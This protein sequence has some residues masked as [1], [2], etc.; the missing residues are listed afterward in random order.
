MTGKALNDAGDE[1]GVPLYDMTHLTGDLA[2][3]LDAMDIEKAIFTGHDWGGFV[4]WQMPFLPPHPHGRIDWR[5]HP[6]C[7]APQR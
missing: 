3:L 7:A 5:Q 2:H 1:S 6:L 4:I